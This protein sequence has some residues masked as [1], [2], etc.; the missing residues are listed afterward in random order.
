MQ[1]FHNVVNTTIG[2]IEQKNK[3]KNSQ[4]CKGCN[5]IGKWEPIDSHPIVCFLNKKCKHSRKVP[6]QLLPKAVNGPALPSSPHP[7]AQP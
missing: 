2:T 3:N 7:V 5:K 6:R 4:L 1:S